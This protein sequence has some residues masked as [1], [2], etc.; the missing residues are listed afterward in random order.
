M[1]R[2]QVIHV[3]A[4]STD[5]RKTYLF[6]RI[7]KFDQLGMK[8]VRCI[9][10]GVA[11]GT[12]KRPPTR[13]RPSSMPNLGLLDR[14]QRSAISQSLSISATGSHI[15]NVH[16]PQLDVPVETSSTVHVLPPSPLL[17]DLSGTFD[18]ALYF[19]VLYKGKP[20]TSTPCANPTTAKHIKPLL[21]FVDPNPPKPSMAAISFSSAAISP[22]SSSSSS[23]P[24]P[25]SI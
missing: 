4:I 17:L 16:V 20:A 18:V 15:H 13:H 8:A 21:T 1:P 6:H 11:V 24:S 9:K 14:V 25:S 2:P 22:S 12:L 19:L 7:S 23:L 10:Q 5:Q 3:M